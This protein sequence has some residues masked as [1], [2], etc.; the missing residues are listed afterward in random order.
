MTI[1]LVGELGLEIHDVLEFELVPRV[2]IPSAASLSC[3]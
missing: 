1:K 2:T 3:R